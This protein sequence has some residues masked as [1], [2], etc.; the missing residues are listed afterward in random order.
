VFF[1]F[2]FMQGAPFYSPSDPH[3]L[4]NAWNAV[5]Y[6]VTVIAVM[7]FMVGFDLWPLHKSPAL[8][9][10]PVLGIVWTI[11]AGVLAGVVFYAGLAVARMDVAAFMVEVPIPFIFGTIIVLNMLQGSLFSSLR[12]PVKGVLNVVVIAVVGTGL[13]RIYGGLSPMVTGKLTPGGPTY[14]FEIWLA[15][16]LLSVTFPFLVFYAE[17]FKLWPLRKAQ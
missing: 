11:V 3:G 10:Q 15:S 4:F 14:D 17:F 1:D 6:Y 13:A 12:Q 16:A 7:F 2:S 8:M 9:K 5:V